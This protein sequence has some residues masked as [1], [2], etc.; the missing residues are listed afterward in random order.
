M[1]IHIYIYIYTY[2]PGPGGY[3]SKST[4]FTMPGQS[5]P[6]LQELL[7]PSAMDM[8]P[9]WQADIVHGFGDFEKRVAEGLRA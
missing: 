5:Q 4:P 6:S 7:S 8:P 9:G 2:I 3:K 1:Y